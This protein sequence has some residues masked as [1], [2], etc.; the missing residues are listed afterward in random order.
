MTYIF[1]I[2]SYATIYSSLENEAV[3]YST[4][5]MVWM[6]SNLIFIG[7]WDFLVAAGATIFACLSR[8]Q[9]TGYSTFASGDR[10]SES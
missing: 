4:A 2:S 8:T 3:A 10:S 6:T 7:L 5:V 1:L 9:K